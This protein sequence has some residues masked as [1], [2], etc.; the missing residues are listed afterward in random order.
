MPA[1]QARRASPRGTF[2]CTWRIRLDPRRPIRPLPATIQRSAVRY[3]RSFANVTRRFLP[4]QNER[5]RN[6]DTCVSR[7]SNA[8]A[9][10]RETVKHQRHRICCN[11]PFSASLAVPRRRRRIRQVGIACIERPPST[12]FFPFP[13]S[14]LM[15]NNDHD[16]EDFEEE[17]IKLWS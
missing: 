12:H 8:R 6:F 13:G 2:T 1:H 5:R 7:L 14:Y 11:R 3:F 15:S 17:P 16:D 9:A 10:R 4:L